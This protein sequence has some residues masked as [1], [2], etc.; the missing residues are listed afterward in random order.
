MILQVRHQP[1]TPAVSYPQLPA[2]SSASSWWRSSSRT[3][4]KRRTLPQLDNEPVTPRLRAWRR[5]TVPAVLPSGPRRHES[6]GTHAVLSD[7]REDLEDRRDV[8][9]PVAE[10]VR[11]GQH[12]VS[13]AGRGQRDPELPTGLQREA[14]VLAHEAHVEPGVLGEIEHEWGASLQHRRA[15]RAAGHHLEG[16]LAVDPVALR[17]QE[18][19]GE[20]EHL[21]GQADV[22][23]QLQDQTLPV[24]A[25]PGGRA[26]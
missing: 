16:E 7:I 21:H 5:G 25:D 20:R 11:S 9:M 24:L 17:H 4:V 18:S 8:A 1:S 14:D 13:G 19:L 12:L 3:D 22:D 15:D 2:W 10:L 26:E 23:R 6:A